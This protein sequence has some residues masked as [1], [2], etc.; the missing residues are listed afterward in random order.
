[1]NHPIRIILLAMLLASQAGCSGQDPGTV[2]VAVQDAPETH[3]V[4][5]GRIDV[6]GGLLQLGA[7]SDGIISR[8]AVSEGQAV[9]RGDLLLALDPAAARIEQKLAQTRLDAAQAQAN[10]SAAQAASAARTAKRLADAVVQDA[11]DAQSADDARTAATVAMTGLARTRADVEIARAERERTEYV[12]SQ[13]QLHAPVD[14]ETLRVA[15]WP[16]MHVSPQ[17]GTLLELLPAK[18]RIVRAELTED[19][20]AMIAPGGSAQVL[21]DDG[22]QTVLGAAHVLRIGRTYGLSQLQQDP[23]QRLNQRS[24]EVVLTFDHPSALRIG[25]RVLVRF[26]RAAPAR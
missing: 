17:G 3:V 25:Q 21:T 5:R 8:V 18:A 4:A 12:L 9:K 24:I 23:G 7:P 2:T 11:G 22:R 13:Q 19:F 1:M 10:L 16:G 14:G 15:A 26:A 6:E 20:V